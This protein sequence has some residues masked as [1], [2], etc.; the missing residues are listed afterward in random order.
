MNFHFM[1]LFVVTQILYE[2]HYA[3]FQLHTTDICKIID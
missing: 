3:I 2:L 1:D